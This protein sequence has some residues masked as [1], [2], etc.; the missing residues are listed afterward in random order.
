MEKHFGCTRFVY[1]HFL[2]RRT[3]HY[4]STGKGLTYHDTAAELTELKKQTATEWLKEVNSQSLQQALRNLNTAYNNFF[5]KRAAFPNFKK[6]KGHQSFQVPQHFSLDGSRLSIP[7]MAPIRIV[8]HRPLEGRPRQVTISRNAA[9]EY[10]ASI[11]CEV[12]MP[13][14]VYSGGEV[15]IDLGLTSFLIT[16]TGEKVDPGNYYR[17]A[18]IKLAKLQR[19]LSKKKKGSKN[20][21]KA[22]LAVAKQHQKIA[23]QRTEFQHRLSLRLVRENQVIHTEGLAVKNMVKNHHLAKSINDA[24]WSEFIRQLEYKGQWYGCY[25]N[26]I[27]RFFPSS[28]R[29]SHCGHVVQSLPLQIRSWVCPE[30]HTRHD[31]DINAAKNILIFGRAGAAQTGTSVQNACG[32]AS[33]GGTK[34]SR[35]TKHRATSQASLKQEALSLAAG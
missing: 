3:D 8:V 2:R 13:A 14:P 30:C 23:N 7:K 4:A 16:S 19:R 33:G 22:R 17:K 21:S 26:Q 25:I 9:E 27:D 15:G 5:N 18:E 34:P 24:A 6:R 11:L 31:R 28:K 32:D 20:R 1:N 29:C 10:F 12:D 35:K